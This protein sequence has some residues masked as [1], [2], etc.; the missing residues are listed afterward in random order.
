MSSNHVADERAAYGLSPGEVRHQPAGKPSLLR[1]YVAALLIF[2]FLL[3]ALAQPLMQSAWFARKSQNPYLT[4]IGYGTRLR[5]AN[6]QVVIAGDSSAMEDIDPLLIQQRTGLS[7]CNIGEIESVQMVNGTHVLDE[8]LAH[9]A[10]PQFLVFFDNPE[11]LTNPPRWEFVSSFEGVFLRTR[12]FP[13]WGMA[14]LWLHHP[15]DMIDNAEFALFLA[16]KW[17]PAHPLPADQVNFREPH[18]GHAVDKGT[19]LTDCSGIF[20]TREPDPAWLS[21]LRQKYSTAGTRVFIDVT[22]LPPCAPSLPYFRNVIKPGMTDNGLQV[23]PL[24][25]FSSSGRGHM[26]AAG[27]VVVSNA[28][29]DQISAAKGAR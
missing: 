27:A 26:T 17:L 29:A 21:G 7:A 14:T 11:D 2:P 16:L 18:R 25:D 10:R 20:A 22:P 19:S 8:Y 4:T 5:N 9:N 28:V 3:L 1:V 12:L 6:C 15:L 13:Q 23:E 24:E